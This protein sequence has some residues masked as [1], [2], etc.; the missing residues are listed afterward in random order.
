MD[1]AHCDPAAGT[2]LGG[3]ETAIKV[4]IAGPFG[5]GKTTYVGTLSDIAPLRT[6]EVMTTASVASD[7]LRG[8]P[9]KTET[10]VAMDFGRLSLAGGLVLYLFGAPGQ[11]R[12]KSVLQD[13][14]RGALGALVLA[15]TRRLEASYPV[16]SEM[17]RLD[18]PYAVAVNRFPDAPDYPEAALR[19]AMDLPAQT[20]L[21]VCDARERGSSRD[22]LVRL[23]EHLLTLDPEPIP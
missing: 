23:V 3:D 2:H 11:P 6:E 1:S 10:T 12:F 18:L 16:M 21:V 7:D 17:E 4:V 8:L 22:A 13:L 20:P 5:V 19:E 14:A 15:D 9:N